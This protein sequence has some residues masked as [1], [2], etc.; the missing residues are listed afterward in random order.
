MLKLIAMT[1]AFVSLLIV[2]TG[3]VIL[4]YTQRR[5]AAVEPYVGRHRAP[6]LS[7]L[8]INAARAAH[9]AAPA[10]ALTGPTV[11][12]ELVDELPRGARLPR[13]RSPWGTPEWV[14]EWTAEY[15]GVAA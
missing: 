7:T 13:P 14:D 11:P 6:L 15:A 12:L 4:V 5:P 9:N 10:P 3:A 1:P 8:E 2:I